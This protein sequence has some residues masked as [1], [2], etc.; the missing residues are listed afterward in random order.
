MENQNRVSDLSNTFSFGK[1]KQLM[2]IPEMPEQKETP[3]VSKE[4]LCIQKPIQD[5]NLYIS[6]EVSFKDDSEGLFQKDQNNEEKQLETVKNNL[7]VPSIRVSEEDPQPEIC[8]SKPQKI[9]GPEK[10]N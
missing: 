7:K 4:R 9:N 1:N 5:P 8:N 3:P 6:K 2:F 10:H